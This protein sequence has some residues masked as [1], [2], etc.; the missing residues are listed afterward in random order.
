MV[1][2]LTAAACSDNDGIST[3]DANTLMQAVT[4]KVGDNAATRQ[5]GALPQGSGQAGD[6]SQYFQ[7]DVGG[8]SKRLVAG[9][10]VTVYTITLQVPDF[11]NS[12]AFTIRFSGQ[13]GA[14]FSNVANLV[15]NV[16][17]PQATARPVPL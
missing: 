10:A 15:V 16:G 2:A 11:I 4:V 17:A 14:Q 9:K 8:A 3:A 6:A 12:G 13:S 1:L 7:I 5:I